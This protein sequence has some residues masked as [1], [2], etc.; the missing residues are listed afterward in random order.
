MALAIDASTP[1]MA[2]SAT[3]TCTTASFTPP[4]NSL[5]VVVAVG[6][7]FGGTPTLTVTS[8]GLTFQRLVRSGVAAA[9][10]VVELWIARV[11]SSGGSA[12][13][14]S[15]TTTLSGAPPTS[16]K[17]YVM[18]GWNTFQPLDAVVQT[19][20][21]LTDPLSFTANVVTP[22]SWF[23][24]AGDD[25]NNT[26]V[27]ASTDLIENPT[28]PGNFQPTAV[29]KSAVS[30]A[31]SA[32][33]NYNPPSGGILTLVGAVIRPD[34]AAT[35]AIYPVADRGSLQNIT[36]ATTSV[37]GLAAGA[38][39]ATG[40]YLIAR[41]AID[42]AA[43]NGVASTIT[44]TDPR[45]NT[46]TVVTA[47]NDPG[48]ALA[49]TQVA[50]AYAKVTNAYSNGD[51]LTFNYGG[52]STTAKAIVVEEWAGID[53]TTPVVS[54]TTITGITAAVAISR[55]P[56]AA[57]QLVY[58]AV[59]DE[60]SYNSGNGFTLDADTTDGNW[61][62]LT[63]LASAS[64][65]AASNQWTFGAYK[66]VSG[67]TAQ[68]WNSTLST[69]SD[70]AAAAIVF[71][72]TTGVSL[73]LSAASETDAAVAPTLTKSLTLGRAAETDTAL[74]PTLARTVTVSRAQETDSAFAL[75]Y[76]R[77]VTL[78][79]AQETDSS[80]V[81][82]VARTIGVSLATESDAAHSLSATKSR[83]VTLVSA[84]EVD[85]ALSPSL[86]KTITLG[87]ATET[88]AAKVVIATKTKALAV[89]QETDTA[90]QLST[91]AQNTHTLSRAQETDTAFGLTRAKAK[92]LGV[93]QET[94]T[95]RVLSYSR[96][97][98]LG[99]ASETDIAHPLTAFVGPRRNITIVALGS[100]N[101]AWLTTG[102]ISV[103]VVAGPPDDEW[104]M[105]EPAMETDWVVTAPVSETVI[106]GGVPTASWMTSG[107]ETDWVASGPTNN[108]WATT[109]P[110]L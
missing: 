58:V 32:T 4:N 53:G 43:T 95:A 31:G 96:L 39:I 103:T 27:V 50:I 60:G 67:T 54:S 44:V 78:G 105:S 107:P 85:G 65:T 5:L 61:L 52:V 49:G 88:E 36:A 9:G 94:E 12:R 72:P 79:R 40:N 89:A 17:V 75:S 91:T 84:S 19:A 35:P 63:S 33:L 87:V 10:G 1:T 82:V 110:E 37:V 46:W 90:L 11:G 64:G 93:A 97:I 80:Y 109:E 55:T 104:A 41:L 70:W 68:T 47:V 29:W 98:V 14:V 99:G 21:N 48:A 66:L 45:S 2:A 38:S 28:T 57:N 108:P 26:G 24:S 100:P 69:V 74:A 73:T 102:P 7:W 59:A 34:T 25:W 23:V 15:M 76:A 83:T 13:T 77:A 86:A 71:Q 6:D 101:N 3:A 30:S 106:V 56:T 18:T 20:N 16:L 51:N 42:N 8:S 92:T 62:P 22:N 81:V